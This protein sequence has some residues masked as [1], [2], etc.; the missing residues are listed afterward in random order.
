MKTVVIVS[1]THCGSVFGLTPPDY[2]SSFPKYKQMQIETWNAYLKIVNKWQCPDVLLHN[3]DMIEGKQRK[4]GGAELI[5]T[6]RNVQVDMAEECL[7]RWK[8]KKF[9][10]TYG[11]PYHVSEH[12]EDFEYNV[13]KRLKGTIEGKLF[14]N[15]EGLTFEAKHKIGNS[16]IPHG[17]ATALL[18][19]MTWTLL[20]HLTQNE[21]KVD[22]VI[23]SHVHRFLY[24]E[25]GNQ[26]GIVT[27]GL[28]L[29]RGRYG[30]RECEGEIH[31]GAI[32]LE[33]N[34]GKITGKDVF[35]WNLKANKPQVI[36]I[37]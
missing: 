30:S 37:K 35:I 3:G 34:K 9:L 27:P 29:K 25:T 20:N 33:V 14:F 17:K 5:T 11:T 26:V 12:A 16:S 28:Q 15:L 32:R 36:K 7:K 1:D 4:Q 6:D 19:S 31:W 10:A 2:F 18:R 24:I 23:R 22:V 21:P 13:A 8:A